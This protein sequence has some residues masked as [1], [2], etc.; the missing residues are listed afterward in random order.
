MRVLD[1]EK[2]L[3]RVEAGAGIFVL[4]HYIQHESYR[5]FSVLVVCHILCSGKFRF[6]INKVRVCSFEEQFLNYIDVILGFMLLMNLKILSI[7][8]T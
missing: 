3:G 7:I 6:C 2:M 8:Q 4:V 5:M 1:V